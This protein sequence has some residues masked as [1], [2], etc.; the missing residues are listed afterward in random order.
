MKFVALAGDRELPS[1]GRSAAC[2]MAQPPLSASRS[3]SWRI[4][5]GTALFVRGRRHVARGAAFDLQAGEAALHDARPCQ[6][7]FHVA[8]ARAAAAG[9]GAWRTRRVARGL[10]RTGHAV[11]CCSADLGVQARAVAHPGV[12]LITA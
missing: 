5:R 7:L 8:Q 11:P 2:N 12:E 1:R 9:R 3:A 6:A 4:R 10:C